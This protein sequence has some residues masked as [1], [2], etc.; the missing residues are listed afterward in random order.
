MTARA[1]ILSVMADD[2]DA[3]RASL[4]R[5]AFQSCPLPMAVLDDA[6]TIVASN[7]ALAA[8]AGE[9]MV[10]LV[11][12]E[13]LVEVSDEGTTAFVEQLR[14]GRLPL[15][16]VHGRLTAADGSVEE[17]AVGLRAMPGELLLA[18]LEDVAWSAGSTAVTGSHGV[19][20][21]RVIEDLLQLLLTEPDADSGVAVLCV[22]LPDLA[23]EYGAAM[24]DHLASECERRLGEQLRAG[25]TAARSAADELIVVGRAD[26]RSDAEAMRERLLTALEEPLDFAGRALEISVRVGLSWV[27]G[28]EHDAERVLAAARTNA[29]AG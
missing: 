21:V 24:A 6:G 10:A 5:D 25:D 3:E 15:A 2:A 11:G 8:V 26:D 7:E 16:R 19:V 28:D 18:Y 22:R 14:S 13:L 29:G 17:V 9:D 1:A 27:H 20:S 12:R 4:F 23:A